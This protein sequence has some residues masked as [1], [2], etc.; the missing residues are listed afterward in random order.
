MD[1]NLI[2]MRAE[3][4]FLKKIS[5]C[6]MEETVLNSLWTAGCFTGAS[7]VQTKGRCRP[8]RRKTQLLQG[9]DTGLGL[10]GRVSFSLGKRIPVGARGGIV[11][12]KR[13]WVT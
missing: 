3:L 6:G 9:H 4:V 2:E 12:R 7:S 13:K 11:F 5:K 8:G 1:E 10:V